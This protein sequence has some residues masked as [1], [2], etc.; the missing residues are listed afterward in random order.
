MLTKR[1]I[2]EKPTPKDFQRFYEINSNP[3][4]NLFNPLGAMSYEVAKEVFHKL[5]EHWENY[6]FGVW[7]IAEKSNPDY[8]IGFGG[9]ANR[10][11]GKELK[12]N[13]GFRLGKKYWGKGYATE[14]AK[15]AIEF[16]F[17]NLKQEAIYGLVRPKNVASIKVLEK[18][19]MQMVDTLDDVPN[20]EK[21]LVFK[22]ENKMRP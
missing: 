16:G 17:K 7:S 10:Y 2:L 4:N 1:L 5:L 18:C 20:E 3:Q 12:L 19:E 8:K 13:L 9:L 21:S 22:I 6:D 14:L 11:Y 15:T